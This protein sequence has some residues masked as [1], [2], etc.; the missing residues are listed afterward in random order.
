MDSGVHGQDGSHVQHHVVQAL[1]HVL[2]NATTHHLRTVGH[3]AVAVPQVNDLAT[4]QGVQVSH[5]I[6]F[7]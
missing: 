7:C 6:A 2:D 5:T 3:D 1:S 4:E